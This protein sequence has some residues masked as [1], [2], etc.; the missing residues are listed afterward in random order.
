[1]VASPDL[2]DAF[3]VDELPL[4]FILKRDSHLA[5]PDARL[6][7]RLSSQPKRWLTRR[8]A[9]SRTNHRSGRRK[10]MSDA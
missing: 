9:S 1:M 3:D 5:E 8:T 6:R 7:R 4:E 2:R 10:V